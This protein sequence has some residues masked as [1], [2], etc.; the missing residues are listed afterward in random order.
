M[1]HS[2]VENERFPEQAQRAA[3]ADVPDRRRKRFSAATEGSRRGLRRN[4]ELGAR[5]DATYAFESIAAHVTRPELH[6]HDTRAAVRQ[7][8]RATAARQPLLAQ[9]VHDR[10][11]VA[12]RRDDAE[13][14]GYDVAVAS[15]SAA[16]ST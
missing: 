13:T 9:G 7:R 6:R 11:F 4:H 16:R 8:E 3:C 2:G 15:S 12:P 14:A 10:S 1:L 5:T